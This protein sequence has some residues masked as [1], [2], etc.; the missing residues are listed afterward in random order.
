MPALWCEKSDCP[1][2]ICNEIASMVTYDYQILSNIKFY[3][4]IGILWKDGLHPLTHGYA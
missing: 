2:D 1:V 4:W 3:G